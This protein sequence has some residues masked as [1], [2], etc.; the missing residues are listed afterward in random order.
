M[1]EVTVQS[2]AA[3]LP[4][5]VFGDQEYPRNPLKYRYSIF[6]VSG[7]TTHR[8]AQPVISSIRRE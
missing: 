1:P 7:C 4:M 2:A 5:P 3:E 8:P 6:V